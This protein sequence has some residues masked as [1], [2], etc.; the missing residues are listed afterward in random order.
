MLSRLRL[1]LRSSG[2]IQV[3]GLSILAAV[4]GAIVWSAATATVYESTAS[5]VVRASVA[6][7]SDLVRATAT[8]STSDE[9][10]ATF[11]SIGGSDNLRDQTQEAAGLSAAAMS[12]I[13]V[14][15]EVI[16]NTNVL[17][18]GARGTDPGA[19]FAAASAAGA[20]LSEFISLTEPVFELVPLDTAQPAEAT[21]GRGGVVF[22]AGAALLG[23]VVGF[24][25]DALLAR[26]EPTPAL[27]SVLDNNV[28]VFNR[29]YLSLRLTEERSRAALSA[30]PF[31]V[32]VAQL[33]APED[34]RI[35]AEQSRPPSDDDLEFLVET[36]QPTLRSQDILGHDGDGR[37]VV[38]FPNRHLD[39]ARAT[40]EGWRRD[41]A[42][43]FVEEGFR[44]RMVVTVA[45]CEYDA[46]MFVGDSGAQSVVT[47]L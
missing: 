13:T 4:M 31:S 8:L 45:A 35:S 43:A 14:I 34:L 42:E 41:G 23:A 36:I 32:G 1:L 2:T 6:D 29:R 18:V 7:E 22:F 25:L 30:R 28:P 16:P 17:R 44:R 39:D 12:D 15:S 24:A 11:A 5:Y 26:K 3:V 10:A 27:R 20:R 9:I 40:V 37:L 38:I 47:E 21:A 19:T 46:G 33:I